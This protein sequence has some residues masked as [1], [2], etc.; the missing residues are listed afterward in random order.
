LGLA[1]EVARNIVDL[2]KLSGS[3]RVQKTYEK[4]LGSI[5]KVF[6]PRSFDE[7]WEHHKPRILDRD[8]VAL[9]FCSAILSST[10]IENP[11]D[12]EVLKDLLKQVESLYADVLSTEMDRDLKKIVLDNLHRI[13]TAIHDYNLRG[14]DGLEEA[15]A[16]AVGTAT[17]HPPI[18]GEGF[19]FLERWTVLMEAL[20]KTL[21]T[22]KTSMVLLPE[23]VEK[24][25]HVLPPGMGGHT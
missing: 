24:V 20:K 4:S 3:T 19:K 1:A 7:N 21:E 15:L 2:L 6:C 22:A 10:V 25:R 14:A 5:L 16:A 23:F 11:V 12:P 8:I 13:K 18:K 9:E 17:I